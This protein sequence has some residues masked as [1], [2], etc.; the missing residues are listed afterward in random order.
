MLDEDVKQFNVYL[1]A[2]LIRR[3]TMSIGRFPTSAAL[4]DYSV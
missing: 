1:P 2:E 4:N 3:I